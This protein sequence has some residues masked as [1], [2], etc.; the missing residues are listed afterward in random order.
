MGRRG[1]Y[2]LDQVDDADGHPALQDAQD[3]SQGDLGAP[4]GTI[5]VSE[6]QLQEYLNANKEEATGQEKEPA[7]KPSSE[8]TMLDAD[9]L[10]EAWASRR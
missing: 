3:G 4:R 2:P 7:P 5:R 10:R 6:E 8:F 9:R 1:R